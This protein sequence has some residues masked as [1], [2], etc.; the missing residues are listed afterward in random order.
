[1][2]RTDIIL[3]DVQR[4]VELAGRSH[5]DCVYLNDISFTIERN[6]YAVPTNADS[7][8]AALDVGWFFAAAERGMIIPHP[9]PDQS[10]WLR[11]FG[12]DA[13]PYGY[14]WNLPYLLENIHYPDSWRR[15]VLYNPMIADEPPCVLC[16]QF[17]PNGDYLDIT[18]TMR[19]SDVY[20]ILPQDVTMTDLILKRIAEPAGLRPGALT[21]NIGNAHAYYSDMEY[22]EEF[23]LDWGD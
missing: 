21:F 19:S 2:N 22:V 5:A 12:R 20:G 10:F 3:D 7:P 14:N 16:Y 6:S 23:T 11:K 8:G 18:A 4:E 13:Y 17:H 9:A 15:C 1:M